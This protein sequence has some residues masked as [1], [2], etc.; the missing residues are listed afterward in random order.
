MSE[1][2]IDR[3]DVASPGL[4]VVAWY[5]VVMEPPFVVV[6]VASVSV[7]LAVMTGVRGLCVTAFETWL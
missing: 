5:V 2:I 4:V 1:D 7:V 3:I 6:S